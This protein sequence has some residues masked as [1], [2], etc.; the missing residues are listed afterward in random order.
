MSKFVPLDEVAH[1]DLKV[2]FGTYL[3]PELSLNQV[4]IYPTEFISVSREFPIFFRKNEQGQFFAIALLGLDKDENLFLDESKR[5]SSR[6]VPAVVERGPFALA[7]PAGEEGN[8]EAEAVLHLDIE[9]PR[10][11]QSSGERL[12]LPHGGQAPYLKLVSNV[13]RRIHVGASMTKAFFD[14]LAKYELIEPMTV[15]ATMSEEL[16]YTVPD[17]YSVSKEKLIQLSAEALFDLNSTGLLEH[18]FA[19]SGSAENFSHIVNLKSLKTPN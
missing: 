17:L 2:E 7:V 13:M 4:P 14:G 5:W 9:D 16:Q 10:V 6:Y 3:Q 15:Q 12:F 11:G 1:A 8:P 18:C 19:I